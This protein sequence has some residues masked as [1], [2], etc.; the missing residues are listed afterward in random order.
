M[1]QLPPLAQ[2]TGVFNDYIARQTEV[3][4]VEEKLLSFTGDSF[5]V[6]L[7]SGAPFL[8]VQ[9]KKMS[10]RQRK[11]VS[12]MSGRHIFSIRSKAS[13][14]LRLTFVAETP[15]EKQVLEVKFSIGKLIGTKA[16]VT[17][18]SVSGKEESF[19]M[20]G[21]W[22]TKR[23][24]IKDDATGAVVALISRATDAMHLL[25]GVQTYTVT[26][27]PNMDMALVMAMCIALDEK[28]ETK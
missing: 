4:V 26:I 12:D 13:A 19:T 22:R 20:E 1:T 17:F 2:R 5:N 15:D 10:L 11:E 16:Y 23:A 3:L 24:E 7:A 6:K 27:A 28:A 14:L 18:T 8:K 9:G 25:G 21:D